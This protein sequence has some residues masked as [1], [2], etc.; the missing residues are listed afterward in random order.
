MCSELAMLG[1]STAKFIERRRFLAQR[2][3]RVLGS[4]GAA[5]VGSASQA[6]VFLPDGP[7]A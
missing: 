1:Y 6:G 4:E 5:A 7:V 2:V 3:I